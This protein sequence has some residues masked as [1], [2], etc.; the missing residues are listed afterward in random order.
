MPYEVLPRASTSRSNQLRT[1]DE[2]A[3]TEDVE[4][5]LD[6]DHDDDDDDDDDD[7]NDSALAGDL[8][9]TRV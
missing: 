6:G 3:D 8:R 7:R 2:H 4:E 9:A 1:T 5:G